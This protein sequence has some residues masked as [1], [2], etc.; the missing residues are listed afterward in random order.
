MPKPKLAIRPIEKNISI[1]EDLVARINL[2]L[3]SPLEGRVPHG[4]WSE[5]VTTLLRGYVAKLDQS[6][7]GGKG[8]A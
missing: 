5:L 3:M 1:P 7:E 6:K 8:N 2:E 4:K